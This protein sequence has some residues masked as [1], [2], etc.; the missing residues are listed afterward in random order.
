MIFR[1]TTILTKTTR[2]RHVFLQKFVLLVVIIGD[3]W[4]ITNGTSDM[5]YMLLELNKLAAYRPLVRMHF[6]FSMIFTLALSASF[7]ALSAKT[8]QVE[9]EFVPIPLSDSEF[10]QVL[11]SG[12]GWERITALTDKQALQLS[13]YAGINIDERFISRYQTIADNSSHT[14]NPT[15]TQLELFASL[16]P[17]LGNFLGARAVLPLFS[18]KTLTVKQAESIS[19]FQGHTLLL[20]SLQTLTESHAKALARFRGDWN[21]AELDLS[22]LKTLSEKSARAL[23]KFP[24]DQLV[25][26]G[27]TKIDDRV[28]LAFKESQCGALFLNGLR[29]LS[30]NQARNLG[31]F[32]GESLSFSALESITTLQARSLANF[33]G[34]ALSLRG[35]EITDDAVMSELSQ[36]RGRVLDLSGLRY[37]S[38]GQAK[39][40]ANYS[41][42]ELRLAGLADLS[43]GQAKAFGKANSQAL[44]LDNIT[45]LSDTQIRSLS[46]FASQP[47][48][49]KTLS[50]TSLNK[51]DVSAFSSFSGEN[52][53]LTG[54][55]ELTAKKIAALLECHAGMIWLNIGVNV[56]DRNFATLR[57]SDSVGLVLPQVTSLRRV[58]LQLLMS[59]QGGLEFSHI[60]EL[61][62]LFMPALSAWEGSAL[63]FDGVRELLPEQSAT[64]S[65]F[66]CGTLRLSGLRALTDSDITNLINYSGRTIDVNGWSKRARVSYFQKQYAQQNK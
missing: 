66:N 2:Q 30:L 8:T 51:I 49:Q 34:D 28:S 55:T 43:D 47:E 64:L 11:E 48:S 24:G 39:V 31:A 53:Y 37:L 36:F 46:L 4:K 60:T 5:L 35:L 54:L 33:S 58:P 25:L 57:E 17:K 21:Y 63:H 65:A 56:S 9:E 45:W 22:G 40:L 42:A 20:W 52:L 14:K 16:A 50:L 41:G 19:Y 27:L 61:D 38:E 18:L 62:E 12:R 32:S 15:H 1:K 44:Y 26:D 10:V 6:V 59:W 3:S 7:Q 29:Q 13:H 23:A